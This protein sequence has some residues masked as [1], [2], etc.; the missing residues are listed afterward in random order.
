MTLTLN[1]PAVQHRKRVHFAHACLPWC[2]ID[3]AGVFFGLPT[4]RRALAS[5]ARGRNVG[6]IESLD[7]LLAILDVALSAGASAFGAIRTGAAGS[8]R[9][10]P[11]LLTPSGHSRD[12]NSAVQR[13]QV[14]PRASA[15][16]AAFEGISS[17]AAIQSAIRAMHSSSVVAPTDRNLLGRS[18]RHKVDDH[19]G[20]RARGRTSCP[21]AWEAHSARG[22]DLGT[23]L[24]QR[25]ARRAIEQH[26]EAQG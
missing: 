15:A 17:L 25:A 9:S 18:G 20:G 14:A 4:V 6:L 22:D 10:S 13:S 1:H 24:T 3:H 16:T 21:G 2:E 5:G 7:R 26:L 11:A 19:H 23:F 12:R 8:R